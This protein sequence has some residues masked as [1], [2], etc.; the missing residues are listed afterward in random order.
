MRV[1]FHGHLLPDRGLEA[2]LLS[3][4]AWTTPHTLLIRGDGAPSYVSRLKSLA[5]ERGLDARVRFEPAVPADAVVPAA[6]R[7]ADLGVFFT[8]LRTGQ[9]H[10]NLPNKLFEYVAAG[11]GVAVSPGADLKATV[12]EFGIGVVSAAADP[13]A[14]ADAING[15]TQERMVTFKT[16]SRSAAAGELCWEAERR[17]LAAALSPHLDGMAGRL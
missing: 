10:F 17:K 14:I 1:L 13:Q 15:L 12:D 4:S 9:H 16:A 11:L 8:P 7:S 6:A 5:L 2:L 3:M